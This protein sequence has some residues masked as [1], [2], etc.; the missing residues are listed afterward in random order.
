MSSALQAIEDR[1]GYVCGECGQVV[2]IVWFRTELHAVFC[3]TRQAFD[4]MRVD[5]LRTMRALWAEQ[6]ATLSS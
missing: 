2:I 4:A 1:A 6:F 5:E 3:M